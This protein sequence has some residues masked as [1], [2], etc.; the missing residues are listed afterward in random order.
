MALKFKHFGIH[1]YDLTAMVEFYGKMFGFVVSDYSVDNNLQI[2]FLTSN[3]ED[4]HQVALIGGRE[5]GVVSRHLLNQI[6]YKADSLNEVLATYR[7]ARSMGLDD[8][9]PVSHGNSWSC[10]FRDPEGNRQEV[11]CDT[12][13]YVTQPHFTLMNFDQ[14][15]E[16]LRAETEALVRADPSFRL[17]D[18][19]KREIRAKIEAALASRPG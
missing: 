15:A 7:C 11:Y 14:P 1:V 6:S 5:P 18:D 19:W 10:Y 4:H 3:P 17:R 2:A 16:T 12:P 13:W 8:I 9:E